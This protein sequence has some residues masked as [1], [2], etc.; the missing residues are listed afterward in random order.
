MQS[1]LPLV[2][3]KFAPVFVHPPDEPYVTG[4]PELPPVAA[5]VKPVP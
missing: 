5:T 4:L 2:I 1:V 3:V